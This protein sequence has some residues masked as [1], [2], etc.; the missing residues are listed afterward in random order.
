MK[1]ILIQDV[2]SLGKKGELVEVSQGYARNLLVKK[3]ALEANSKNLNDLKLQ[4]KNVEKVAQENLEHAEALAAEIKDKSVTL[5]IKAGEGGRTFGSV[6]S[7]E[8]AEACK[9]QLGLEVDK[10]KLVLDEPIRSLGVTE[11]PLKLHPKVTATIR[12]HV[13]EE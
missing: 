5:K 13:V 9:K 2:K 7:K 4:Q 10:K 1:L 3:Q 11:V 8:I 12:V 6:S